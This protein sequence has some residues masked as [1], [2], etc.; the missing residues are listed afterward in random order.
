[1]QIMLG[2]DEQGRPAMQFNSFEDG[3]QWYKD[4]RAMA[5]ELKKT[6]SGGL[7]QWAELLAHNFIWALKLVG[8]I[9]PEVIVSSLL[10]CFSA[11]LR[12]MRFSNLLHAPNS[13]VNNESPHPGGLFAG[14]R[15]PVVAILEF[16]F[17][18]G[19][20]QTGGVSVCTAALLAAAMRAEWSL[21]S[22]CKPLEMPKLRSYAYPLLTLV[23]PS[24][25]GIV[26]KY[27]VLPY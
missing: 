19:D 26:V 7:F 24:V 15:F 27:W 12:S 11:L 21:L 3:S 10:P 25:W 23:I 8:S 6:M 4:A 18:P 9:I 20:L 22:K 14:A 16:T 13:H 2:N 1:M 5:P 17:R